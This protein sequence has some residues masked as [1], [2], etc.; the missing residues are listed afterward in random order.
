MSIA[1][2]KEVTRVL[3]EWNLG[4]KDAPARLMPFVYEELRLRA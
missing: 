3:E 2:T 4:D 1:P